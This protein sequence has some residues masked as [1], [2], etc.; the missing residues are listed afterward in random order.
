MGRTARLVLGVPIYG[1]LA[2]VVAFGGLTLF[3][4]SLNL[5]LAEYALGGDLALAN[6]LRILFGLYPFVG[7]A[8]TVAQG[9]L[10]VVVSALLGAD[11][12]M[13][14]YHLREHAVNVESGG[15]SVIGVVLGTLGAG[16]AACGVP[17]LLGLL[18]LVGASSAVLLLPLDGLEFALLAAVVL[19]L[20]VHWLA[21]GMRGGSVRGCPVDV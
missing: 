16:C 11:V 20:S 6:R 1:A 13:A 15:A 19:V 17:I 2:V 4:T 12:A 7:S 18:S 8:Y 14:I 3:S 10:V 5:E 9:S 21:D